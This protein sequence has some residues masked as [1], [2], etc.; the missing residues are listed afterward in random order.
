MQSAFL[1]LLKVR[2]MEQQ[3]GQ[4]KSLQSR[5]RKGKNLRFNTD[6]LDIKANPSHREGSLILDRIG[7]R[8]VSQLRE[9]ECT[10]I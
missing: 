2:K 10:I 6:L 8:T 9:V 5:K 1:L 7:F 3:I 4:Q